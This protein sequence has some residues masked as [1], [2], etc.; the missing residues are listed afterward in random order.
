MLLDDPDLDRL[1]HALFRAGAEMAT[2]SPRV[3]EIVMALGTD[4]G[5]V[6]RHSSVME[7]GAA[8]V[9]WMTHMLAIADSLREE[10]RRGAIRPS[11][12]ASTSPSGTCMSPARSRCSR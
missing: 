5:I 8:A 11:G 6:L 4:G 3:F 12:A 9:T 2:T 10:A 7:P 1:A